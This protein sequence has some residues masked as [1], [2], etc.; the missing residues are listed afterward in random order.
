MRRWLRLDA[1][2]DDT[3]WVMLLGP[4]AQLAWIKLLCYAKRDGRRGVVHALTNKAAAKKWGVTENA[5]EDM[6]FQARQDG[7][8][9]IDGDKWIVTKWSDYQEPD[10]DGWAKRKQKQRQRDA[11]AEALGGSGTSMAYAGKCCNYCGSTTD[12]VLEHIRPGSKGGENTPTNYQILCRSCNSRKRSRDDTGVEVRPESHPDGLYIAGTPPP[13]RVT[14]RDTVA[15]DHRPPTTDVG[16]ATDAIASGP[17]PAELHELVRRALHHG[18][19]SD[20]AG[21]SHSRLKVMLETMGPT[22][23]RDGIM[24]ICRLRG[25]GKISG[26]EPHFGLRQALRW[27]HEGRQLWDAAVDYERGHAAKP[28]PTTASRIDGTPMKRATF[29]VPEQARSA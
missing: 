6:V 23:V 25:E 10:Q 29:Q 2:W 20:E 7:A 8:L 3:E 19:E 13:S 28:A 16:T 9:K 14:D 4:L 21:R 26:W 17:G 15:R 22:E 12:L 5:V 27:H 18:R 1:Q 11:V 24:G